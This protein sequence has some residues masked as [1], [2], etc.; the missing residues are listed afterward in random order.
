MNLSLTSFAPDGCPILFD[1]LLDG[2]LPRGHV[3][4]GRACHVPHS[5]WRAFS[6]SEFPLG[7]TG[8]TNKQPRPPSAAHGGRALLISDSCNQF[9]NH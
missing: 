4:A 8:G 7:V 2:V 1:E 6:F 3:I 5:P 9:L